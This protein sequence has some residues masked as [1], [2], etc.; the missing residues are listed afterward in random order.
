MIKLS[1]G[2]VKV[3]PR[4]WSKDWL[5]FSLLLLCLVTKAFIG[6]RDC[7][8]LPSFFLSPLLGGQFPLYIPF[9]L[10]LVVHLL[11]IHV[12]TGVPVPSITP[13]QLAMSCG[14][15][16]G[17]I[18]GLFFHK[19]GQTVSCGHLMRRW[20]LLLELLLHHA[21]IAVP[22][23]RSFYLGQLGGLSLRVC[24]FSLRWPWL[25]EDRMVLGDAS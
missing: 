3:C 10:I 4:A 13:P 7:N 15:Q 16:G 25:A 17:T 20:Q 1:G 9:P 21:L 11:I 5:F 24:C 19:Y 6:G 23:C 2:R 22:L 8:R 18:Q 12:A 14:K